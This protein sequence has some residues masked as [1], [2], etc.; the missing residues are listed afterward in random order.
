MHILI[1]GVCKLEL[2]LL[3]N[4]VINRKLIT[5]NDL[6]YKIKSSNYFFLDKNDIPPT[7]D[8]MHL[9]NGNFSLSS[10]Q[11]LVLFHN[12][13]FILGF[14]LL[15]CNFYW[16]NFLRL[17][18]IVNISLCFF[19]NDLTVISLQSLIYEYLFHFKKLHPEVEFTPKMHYMIHLP[20]QLVEFGPLRHHSCFRFE[21]KHGQIKHYNYTN[22]KN[23]YKSVASRHQLWMANKQNNP[24]YLHEKE[25]KIMIEELFKDDEKWD[26][27]GSIKSLKKFRR[28]KKNG[29][30][31]ELNMFVDRCKKEE[32]IFQTLGKIDAIY[33]KDDIDLIFEIEI[34][35]VLFYE[36]NVNGFLVKSSGKKEYKNV[37]YF[38]S[39]QC[40]TYVRHDNNVYVQP[41][42]YHKRLNI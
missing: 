25:D 17:L 5:L 22:F 33:E 23:I 31:Y 41:R 39:K 28:F 7:I 11:M 2:K 37:E 38:L 40:L 32:N 4:E 1:E 20:K 18:Q 34:F 35:D 13:P 30:I 26:I 10:G 8:D 9:K 6:N 15:N 16:Q 42:Y 3:L 36:S 21:A 29:F 14:N 27:L 12:L 19:Y 24:N